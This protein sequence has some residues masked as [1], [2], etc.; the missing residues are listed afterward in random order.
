VVERRAVDQRLVDRAEATEAATEEAAGE[1]TAEASNMEGP[2]KIEQDAVERSEGRVEQKVVELEVA[3]QH[4]VV[5]RRTDIVRVSE[6]AS[7][8]WA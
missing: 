2:R 5:L 8:G 7:S 1:E 4:S 3:E 6:G